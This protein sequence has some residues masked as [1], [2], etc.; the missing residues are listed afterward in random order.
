MFL[1]NTLNQRESRAVALEFVR[2]VQPLK[3]AEQFARE[4]HLEADAVVLHRESCLPLVLDGAG[5]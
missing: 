5:S 1:A 4:R 2:A 3:D